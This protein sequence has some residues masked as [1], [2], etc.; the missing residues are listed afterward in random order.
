MLF[1]GVV[2]RGGWRQKGNVDYSLYLILRSST[3]YHSN[4]EYSPRQT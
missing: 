2:Q 1:F 3:T 4:M